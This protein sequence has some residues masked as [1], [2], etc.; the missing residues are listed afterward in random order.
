MIYIPLKVERNYIRIDSLQNMIIE[1]KHSDAIPFYDR[2]RDY[3]V[4]DEVKNLFLIRHAETEYN[5]ESRIGGD[6]GLTAKRKGA[7][8]SLGPVFREKKYFLHF[9]QQQA[10][11]N[12]TAEAIARKQD[13]CRIIALKEFDEINAGVCENMT[14]DEIEKKMPQVFHEREVR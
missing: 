13:N 10:K 3:L 9:Y 1:E 12:N 2:L 11:D 6:S 5:M 7:G 14:Y 8:Q 4:T